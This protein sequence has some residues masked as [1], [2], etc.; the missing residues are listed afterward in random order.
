MKKIKSLIYII[1]I[2]L[3]FL[4]VI[5]LHNEAKASS[6]D[7]YLNNLDFEAK[8]NS[9]GSMDV[10]ET[11]NIDIEDTN[12]LFKTFK[13]DKSKFTGIS[14]VQVK[15]ITNGNVEKNFT[16]INEL[17]YHV[18]KDCYYGMK[19]KEGDFEIAWGVGLDSGR[20]TRTYKI[21]YTVQDAIKNCSGFSEL[22][23][24]FVGEDFEISADK[25]T[26]KITLPGSAQKK[27][28]I[29][30]WGHT[31]DL[32]GE[33]YAT[34]KKTVEFQVNK[35]RHG[36]F[37]EVRVAI[38]EDIYIS[39][40]RKNKELTIQD[41]INEETKWADKAN[42][43]RAMKTLGS[44]ILYIIAIIFILGINIFLAYRIIKN[45]QIYNELPQKFKP[46]QNIKYYRDIPDDSATPG[47]SLLLLK[48][49]LSEFMSQEVGN[50]FSATLLDLSLKGIIGFET[51]INQNG[52]QDI[53]ISI[54]NDN[55]DIIANNRDELQIYSFVK[56]AIVS[57]GGKIT[58]KQLE[59]YIKSHES[60]VLS[61][62]KLLDYFSKERL[63]LKGFTDKKNKEIHEKHVNYMAGYILLLVF[64][65][66]GMI[67]FLAI[68]SDGYVQGIT[69]IAY[70]IFFV[71]FELI[72]WIL[73]SINI[74]I[75]YKTI[76]KI[77]VFTQLGIDKANE[78]KG[79][80]KFMEEFSMLDK[81][82]IPEIAI[83]EKY[84]VY[85][86]AFG[87]ADKVIK[88]LKIVYPNVE[89]SGSFNSS[90][91][92]GLMM[93]TNFSSSFSSSVSSAMSSAYSSG[94]GGGGGFSG[95][96]GRRPEVAGGGGG[97]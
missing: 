9:D 23:W 31:E 19:N 62:K 59:K 51:S 44:H 30:V 49:K 72:S 43:R 54:K 42:T 16:Q 15:E 28:D 63:F 47:E 52:K 29:K 58:T 76:N 89:Q 38:P 5:S 26:G 11:W 81:R 25:I 88:Q 37:V 55:T 92:M 96:G 91:Y 90:I 77:N 69:Y 32:N 12:T 57:Y 50:V 4:F 66:V 13:T 75:K 20:D 68:M 18:T 39:S 73:T 71:W 17:M 34:S 67:F 1:T 97:R 40:A 78:W 56:D 85:A 70:N 82:E 45:K 14:N 41:I 10:T 95:G 93:N 86:T 24:K 61:L 80:K 83:W 2:W 64:S 84:L 33:I 46:Q 94:S 8:V 35:F 21:S 87:I 53:I 3:M 6:G 65:F 79:L 7:L 48:N 60:K 27:E 74:S 22:Y 36:R